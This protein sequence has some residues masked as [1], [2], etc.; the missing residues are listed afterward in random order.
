MRGTIVLLLGALAGAT[1]LA[2]LTP[3]ATGGKDAPVTVR[4]SESSAQVRNTPTPNGRAIGLVYGNDRLQVLKQAPGWYR[5]RTV[6]GVVGWLP[7][8]AVGRARPAPPTTVAA[9][10]K[11]RPAGRKTVVAR[12]KARPA[13]DT[14]AQKPAPKA[15]EA[16]PRWEILA[17][18]RRLQAL[19]HRKAAQQALL[20]VIR[21][22]PGT[23][24]YYEAVRLMLYYV[25]VGEL[26]AARRPVVPKEAME[27]ASRMAA[28]ILLDPDIS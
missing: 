6:R 10:P 28:E 21:N 13:R 26:A 25:P 9:R 11:P 5:V 19:G 7:A 2:P 1:A 20:A 15:A 24:E 4:V 14:I 17:K 22:H 18:G 16:A 3:A 8:D 12:P 23:F 27:R